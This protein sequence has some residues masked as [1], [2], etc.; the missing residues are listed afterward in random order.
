VLKRVYFMT[1]IDDAFWVWRACDKQ[2]RD[3]FQPSRLAGVRLWPVITLQ[4]VWWDTGGR[5]GSWNMDVC[6]N[7]DKN[8]WKVTEQQIEQSISQ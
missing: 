8:G 1:V 3:A 6:P 4:T 2:T 7:A 5:S